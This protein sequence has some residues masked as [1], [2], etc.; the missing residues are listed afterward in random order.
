MALAICLCDM[1][2]NLQNEKKKLID[3]FPEG[4]NS[5]QLYG[6]VFSINI[7]SESWEFI[8]MDKAS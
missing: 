3:E 4:E 1:E 7:T 6:G 5:L 2:S 8:N